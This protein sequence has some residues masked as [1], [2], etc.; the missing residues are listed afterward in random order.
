MV[1]VRTGLCICCADR[2]KVI[3][4]CKKPVEKGP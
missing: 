3:Q 4:E 1:I 2:V